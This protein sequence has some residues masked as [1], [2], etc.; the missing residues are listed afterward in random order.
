MSGVGVGGVG[1]VVCGVV[2]VVLVVGGVV[3]VVVVGVVVGVVVVDVVVVFV[4][5]EHTVIITVRRNIG[6]TSLRAGIIEGV[7]GVSIREFHNVVS[8]VLVLVG[9][10]RGSDGAV[11]GHIAVNISHILVNI[12]RI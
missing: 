1:L 8:L 2:V 12:G 4:I 9:T 6:S 10:I 7:I 5:F 3:R 11:G